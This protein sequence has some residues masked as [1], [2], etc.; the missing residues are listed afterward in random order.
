[1]YIQSIGLA[2]SGF[3]NWEQA[4][5]ILNSEESF[6]I[7]PTD[8]YKITILKPNEARRTSTTI[9]I[10]LQTAEESL[11]NSSFQAD[12]LFSVFVSSDGDPNIL[13]SICQELATADKFVSPTQF[14]NS[15]H[16][17]PAG[18]WSIG[19][20]SMQGINSIACGDCSVAGALIEADSLLQAGEDAVLVVCF[21]LKSPTPLDSARNITYSLSSSMI[22]TRESTIDSLFSAEL[23]LL[24]AKS[25]E[26]TP[27]ADPVLE[28]LRVD[29]PAATGL[30]LLKSLAGKV[31]DQLTL[32]YSQ[33]LSLQ[34]NLTPC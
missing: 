12:Q 22:V 11:S 24:S 33:A 16:N 7:D 8:A 15:V 28:E 6:S 3:N 34:V 9:K 14:H 2:G 23:K 27:I 26:I 5:M 18:Y 29:S 17:A 32:P 21:D 1:M 4:K 31:S 25:A 20:Q 30:P 10:A 13:Q 19:Q